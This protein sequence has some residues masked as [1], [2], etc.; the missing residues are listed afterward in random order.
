[1]A[2]SFRPLALAVTL[3]AGCGTAGI[4]LTQSSSQPIIDGQAIPGE[5]IVQTRTAAPPVLKGVTVRQSLDLGPAGTFHKVLADEAPGAG[6]RLALTALSG[7]VGVTPNRAVV[8]AAPI[9]LPALPGFVMP[10]SADPLSKD[11]WYLP[12]IGTEAAWTRTRGKGVVAAVVDT[13]VDYRHP[14]LMANM[15]STGVSYADSKADGLDAFGHGT[16]VAG[17]IGAVADNAEG[18][19]G[20]APEVRILPVAVLG[21]KGGGSIFSIAQGIKY[22]ADY[23]VTHKVRVVINLSL[24]S[25]TTTEDPISRA[26]GLYATYKGALPVAAAGNHNGEVGSPARITDYY[27]AVAATDPQDAKAA[28][29]CFGPQIAVAAPGVDIMNTTPTFRVPLNEKGVP[30]NYASLRGTS[31]AAP[32]AAGVAALVWSMH[33]EWTWKQVRDHVQRTASDM[34]KAGKDDIYGHGLVNADLA[35]R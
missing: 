6:S 25:A 10:L 17:I 4:P 12:R 24:G 2:H 26:A 21:A 3:V 19:A 30:L 34:G 31:M 27:M 32:V 18:V 14:D 5:W 23:G 35:T 15:A 11:Q 16:H 29:S 28:F 9:A 13:G 22:A 8:L 33:P 1:M 7:V 20:V